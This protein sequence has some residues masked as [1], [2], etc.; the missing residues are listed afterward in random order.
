M[1]YVESNLMPNE[2]VLLKASIHPIVLLPS[3]LSFAVAA[4]FA[5]PAFATP[6]HAGSGAT[7]SSL[8]LAAC[9]GSLLFL[10]NAAQE[11]IRALVY[12]LT[13]E[14]AVTNRR[15]I[16]KRGFIRRHTVEMLLTRVE[17]VSVH[18]NILGRLLNYGT[19]AVTGTGG[20]RESFRA[21]VAPLRVRQGIHRVIEQ[22]TQARPSESA[23]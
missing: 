4:L 13:T 3:L 18:Q 19:I 11:G 21:I 2:K 10:A 17:T 20:T 9:C 12:V 15:I 1:G 14:F 5:L 6:S 22:Y 7:T 23:L 8:A 16:A